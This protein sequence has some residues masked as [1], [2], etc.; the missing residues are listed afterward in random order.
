MACWRTY[1]VKRCFTVVVMMIV[2]ALVSLPTQRTE[3]HDSLFQVQTTELPVDPLAPPC[4]YQH[5][6]EAFGSPSSVSKDEDEAR[7]WHHSQHVLRVPVEAIL[8]RSSLKKIGNGNQSVV[9]KAHL[10]LQ[11]GQQCVVAYKTDMFYTAV[12]DD[13]W[14][15][16]ISDWDLFASCS[17]KRK[18]A[19]NGTGPAEYTSSLL[20]VARHLAGQLELPG[21]MPT[22]AIVLND[23]K[24]SPFRTREASRVM[25]S[26][27]PYRP[28][29]RIHQDYG[30]GKT[31]NELARIM[32]S[33]A[34]G[35]AFLNELGFAHQ[36]ILPSSFKNVGIVQ[37][38][39]ENPYSI[40][41]D[42]GYL[43]YEG[44]DGDT[45]CS[46][47]RACEF[48]VEPSFPRPKME[49]AIENDLN[50]FRAILLK[51]FDNTTDQ[52]R[53]EQMQKGLRQCTNMKEV[54]GVLKKA[55]SSGGD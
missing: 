40:V 27:Q 14:S 38:D 35:I 7:C 6:E 32:V 3:L 43:A 55:A 24:Y 13:Y 47:G 51:L 21:L 5:L 20:P 9:F 50:S 8:N 36:D 33:A 48:C 44:R 15:H 18:R 2:V 34:Q 41:Y 26:I 23:D 46:L 19:R 29:E 10:D 37:D 16:L 4:T 11:N 17:R 39:D 22:W 42:Y 1:S 49:H 30:V 31:P 25:G 45:P 28:M 12:C 52:T 54:I 53:A